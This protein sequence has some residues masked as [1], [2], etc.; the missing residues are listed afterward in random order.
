MLK[1]TLNSTDNPTLSKMIDCEQQ[2][3][4]SLIMICYFL[5]EEGEVL[6]QIDP[7]IAAQIAKLCELVT[8]TKSVAIP[9]DIEPQSKTKTQCFEVKD[10]MAKYAHFIAERMS[11][12]VGK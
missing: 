11:V 10:V 12:M 7:Q 1:S 4:P 5:K 6:F 2:V 8:K 9:D 3:M